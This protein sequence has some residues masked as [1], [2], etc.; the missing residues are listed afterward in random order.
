VSD[1][2]PSP[3]VHPAL[4]GAGLR[5][6]LIDRVSVEVH[7]AFTA[8]GIPCILLKGPAI[9]RWLYRDDEVRG[10]G[11]SDFLIPRGCWQLAGEVLQ[12]L[13][14]ASDIGGMA[15]PRMES[16]ASDPWSRQGIDNVDLHCTFYGLEAEFDDIWSV[17]SADAESFALEGATLRVL[18]LPARTM[19]VAL[20]AAQH[21]EGKAV[22]DLQR[23]VDQVP[24][25]LWWDAVRV[26]QQLGGLPAFAAGLRLV[27]GGAE[28]TEQLGIDRARNASVD[29]RAGRIPL[30]E[31]L[32]ELWE[33]QGIR[34]RLRYAWA[35]LFPRAEFMRWWSPLAKRG[36]VGLAAAYA[37]RPLYLLIRT[38]T[39]ALAVYRARRGERLG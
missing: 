35:E 30:S 29:L 37:W 13:G 19:H 36:P 31:S 1:A 21:T 24:E 18:A 33:T 11:D 23:A 7:E 3:S 9:A 27:D 32:N 6:V 14:F 20:H 25:R 39:A 17:L 2:Q 12:S 38:P 22:Y 34:A 5:N 4:L 28:L 15:H 26:A 10:Y 8:R 16:F